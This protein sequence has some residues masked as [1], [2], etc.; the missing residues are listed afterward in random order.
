VS[1]E[2]ATKRGDI[3]DA[4]D[5]TESTRPADQGP[6]D[7][8]ARFDGDRVGRYLLLREVGRGAMGRV[9][10]GFDPD[11]G[12]RVAVK[13]VADAAR[14]LAPYLLR[15]ARTLAGLSHPNIVPVFDVG[16]DGDRLYIVME[17]V[18]GV[19][20]AT[21]LEERPRSARE[22]V[23]AWCAAGRG[24]AAAHAAGIVHRDVKAS[25]V[26][27]GRDG[28]V[29]VADFGLAR[30][31]DADGAAPRPIEGTRAYLA[32]EV[33]DSGAATEAVDQFAFC[34]SLHRALC[35]TYA[36]RI[37]P[38]IPRRVR[39]V[40]ARG[41]AAEP[42]ARWPS[43]TAMVDALE[44]SQRLPRAIAIGTGAGAVVMAVVS[45]WWLSPAG[46]PRCE[47][48]Q[49]VIDR[50][51]GANRR[52][53]LANALREAPQTAAS[54]SRTM[55]TVDD[56]LA[57]WRTAYAA[58]CTNRPRATCLEARLDE[59]AMQV[60]DA[61]VDPASGLGEIP[62]LVARW[63]DEVA[64]C[65]IGGAPSSAV[66]D[67]ESREYR[68]AMASARVLSGLWRA[69]AATRAAELAIS[70]A[71]DPRA[72]VRARIRRMKVAEKVDP[73]SFAGL[74]ADAQATGDPELPGEVA[75]AAAERCLDLPIPTCAQT[76]ADRLAD[77]VALIRAPTVQRA[78]LAGL[79]G[80]LAVNAGNSAIAI[81][82]YEEETRIDAALLGE[83]SW[84]LL[85]GLIKL[86]GA[87]L[88]VRRYDEALRAATR[89]DAIVVRWVGEDHPFRASMLTAVA[90]AK[91]KL[92]DRVGARADF[93][94]AIALRIAQA[95]DD[96]PAVAGI[97]NNLA[98]TYV[99]DG[100][101]GQALA[102]IDRAIAIY[103]RAPDRDDGY[104][105][106]TVHNGAELA[107]DL[108]HPDARARIDRAFVLAKDR[109]PAEDPLWALL[110]QSRAIIELRAGALDAADADL[111]EAIAR[112]QRPSDPPHTELANA[113]GRVAAIAIR[114]RRL[115]EARRA[116]D[117]AAA[118]L[119]S[120][121]PGDPA[122][123]VTLVSEAELALATG[124]LARV[125]DHLAR[126]TPMADVTPISDPRLVAHAHL[127]VATLAER[128]H[129]RERTAT[130]RARAMAVLQAAGISEA[131]AYEDCIACARP[132]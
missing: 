9:F 83:H 128:A 93:E 30:P 47:A 26:L 49:A 31:P 81:A 43:M 17:L 5:D 60:D 76:W 33:L 131:A 124:D 63:T 34:V 50:A 58:A 115:D 88:D 51:I 94:R 37:D 10:A 48:P 23:R 3:I 52:D 82:L 61:I 127:L 45:W 19:S 71:R 111:H 40:L 89:A 95:G 112:M 38:R 28:H 97:Y 41:L 11:L 80:D 53:R 55:S 119:A 107:G 122:R 57:A 64:A 123:L 67:G 101:L 91:L 16:Q 85:P 75:V 14:E 42:A 72:A 24:L 62:L 84:A 12:R 7:D 36:G 102:L 6:G 15:E 116:L 2:R 117:R 29:R 18:D 78:H 106:A 1:H 73:S 13:L 27:I 59:L 99:E 118:Q 110:F 130:E 100:E 125:R 4:M 121:G 109:I 70:Q 108:A 21:W 79:R 69:D 54:T 90:N 8:T 56:A 77:S 98:A 46:E 126:L 39:G 120:L 114:R 86:S 105:V 103:D 22:I 25:N 132:Q 104:Y 92:G 74:Y 65:T 32:P 68:H 113:E 87:L 20:L 35:G 129:D 66:V 96:V 44:R